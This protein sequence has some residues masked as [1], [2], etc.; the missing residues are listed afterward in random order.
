[1][2]G[3]VLN[4]IELAILWL[5]IMGVFVYGFFAFKL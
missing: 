3:K 1:M 2:S 4:L 5:L